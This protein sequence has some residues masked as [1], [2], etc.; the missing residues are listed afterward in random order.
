[1]INLFDDVVQWKFNLVSL[2]DGLDLAKPS[3]RLM[4][5]ILAGVAAFER[6]I[7]AERILAGHARRECV[8]Y[9]GEARCE[10]GLSR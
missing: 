10:A 1:L 6:E 4:A 3:G 2:R 9:D 8:E 5:N 7:R